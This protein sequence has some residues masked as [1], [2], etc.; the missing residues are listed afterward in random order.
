MIATRGPSREH[1]RRIG[2][3][4]LR[5]VDALRGLAALCVVFHHTFTQF[6]DLYAAVHL[7]APTWHQIAKFISDRNHD[8]VMLFFVL[9]GFSVRLSAGD[10]G[11]ATPSDTVLYLKRRFMR[12]VPL[13]LAALVLTFCVGAYRARL[14]EPSFSWS[15]LAGNLAFLQTPAD[16]RG[17]WVVPF[18]GN[19]P[20]WS[21]SYEMFYYL[22]YPAVVLTI[23]HLGA[24]SRQWLALAVALCLS[25]IG[26]VLFNLWPA[27]PFAF[28]SHF[29]I[30]YLGVDLAERHLAERHLAER[31]L[32]E[33][34]L[35]ERHLGKKSERWMLIAIW[36]LLSAVGVVASTF[37][38]SATL[39]AW[40]IGLAF[41]GTWRAYLS[42]GL[43]TG[44]T[45]PDREKSSPFSIF[46]APLSLIGFIS[47][48]LYLFHY[49]LLTVAAETFGQS[50]TVLVATIA[51]T[52][53][54]AYVAER[55]ATVRRYRI[56]QGNSARARTALH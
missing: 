44:A 12:I 23:A 36:L 39:H 20:L 42:I 9:S 45:E 7:V 5:Y 26:L 2:A 33:R 46:F 16:T 48:A 31:H 37:I 8:A 50:A 49:P 6:P 13:L 43:K 34:H 51:L 38:T 17:T 11:L 56:V 55:L 30:W 40:A 28:L 27:P 29:I 47:Y 54:L 35:A 24:R 18:G 1:G 4:R 14:S 41:Y 3:T 10:S 52:L 32:A 22:L 15:T 19:D 53:A 21:L 25:A